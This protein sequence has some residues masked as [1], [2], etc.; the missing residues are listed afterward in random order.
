MQ[1]MMASRAIV[2]DLIKKL[3]L[4]KDGYTGGHISRVMY[5]SVVLGEIFGYDSKKRELLKL[6]AGLHDL[7]KNDVDNAILRKP[8]PLTLAERKS[9]NSHAGNGIF[10]GI[11]MGYDDFI[12]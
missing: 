4:S 11:K 1:S 2:E 8:G 6:I 10:E 7:G 5:L 12:L 3:M 9:I